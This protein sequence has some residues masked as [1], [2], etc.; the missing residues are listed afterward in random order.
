MLYIH[1][2]LNYKLQWSICLFKKIKKVYIPEQKAYT[3]YSNNVAATYKEKIILYFY[4]EDG[5]LIEIPNSKKS[6]I[7]IFGDQ[8]KEVKLF[9]KENNVNINKEAGLIEVISYYNTL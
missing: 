7:K 9:I 6:K 4:Q 1:Q 3:S 2:H 8:S 5:V